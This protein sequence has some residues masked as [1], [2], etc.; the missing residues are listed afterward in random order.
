M[1]GDPISFYGK[2][3]REAVA[4]RNEAKTRM[5]GGT[6]FDAQ[7]LTF[8]EYL[9]RWLETAYRGSVRERTFDRAES[10]IRVHFVPALGKVKLDKLTAAHI[11]GYYRQLLEAGKSPR[12]IMRLHQT[13]QKALAQ[14]VKWRLIHHNPAPDVIMPKHVKEDMHPL[15]REQVARLLDTAEASILGDV[16]CYVAVL[17]GLRAGELYGLPWEHVDFEGGVL[18]VRQAL[19]QPRSGLTIG[20]P[21]N[22]SSRRVVDVPGQVLDMLR[23]RKAVQAQEKLASPL[24][25]DRWN[26]VFTAPDGSPV[27]MKMSARDHLKPLLKRAGIDAPK[28]RFHDLRHTFATLHFSKRVHPKV[29]QEAM[30]HSS[31][32]ETMDRY[33]HYIPSLG[34]AAARQLG[35]LF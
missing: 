35:E 33:S 18:R 34:E 17:S 29:V 4:K 27:N 31:I 13:A 16:A 26:L 5:G 20:Q 24:W 11:Q 12:T 30:G 22:A 28:T 23:K 21:K 25:L 9:Y 6:A 10:S 7:R 1:G 19:T 14:A 32:T 2:T 8:G 15:T 3:Q